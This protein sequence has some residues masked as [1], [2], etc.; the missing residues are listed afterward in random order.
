[1][2]PASSGRAEIVVAFDEAGRVERA[3]DEGARAQRADG[4]DD[5][6]AA[7][8]ER[9]RRDDAHAASDPAELPRIDV[10][11]SLRPEPATLERA[12]EPASGGTRAP[13]REL[14]IEALQVLREID[15]RAARSESI[16][17]RASLNVSR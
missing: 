8:I 7:S 13:D 17:Y 10:D 1:M 12:R 6:V 4:G 9:L 14:A 16:E 2:R 15:A 11:E 3:A 5:E